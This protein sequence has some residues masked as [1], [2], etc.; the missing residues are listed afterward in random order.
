[1]RSLHALT[2]VFAVVC[3]ACTETDGEPPQS[4]E[5]V[6]EVRPD[7]FPAVPDDAS[8]TLERGP[9]FGSCPVYKVVIHGDGTVV[10]EGELYVA[11]EG[12]GRDTIPRDSVRALVARIDAEGFFALPDPLPCPERMTDQSTATIT[13]RV[14]S[15][16]KEVHHYHG[17]SG[18]DGAARLGALE[19][20]IDRVVGIARWVGDRGL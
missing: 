2:A 6:A 1:M 10:F 8:I 16:A 18:W 3:V 13:V 12:E 11:Q 4:A 17:C 19:R 14:G 20:R 9:C 5:A 15:R 7:T